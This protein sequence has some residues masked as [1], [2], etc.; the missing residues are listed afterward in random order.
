MERGL[1]GEVRSFTRDEFPNKSILTFLV[2]AQKP[3][4]FNLRHATG[5]AESNFTTGL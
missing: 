1:G 4:V 2:T 3:E 5:A